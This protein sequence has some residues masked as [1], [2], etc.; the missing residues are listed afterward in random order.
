[1]TRDIALDS[2]QIVR[3]AYKIAEDKD[4]EGAPGAHRPVPRHPGERRRRV[5]AARCE[6]GGVPGQLS[7]RQ[8]GLLIPCR[9]QAEFIMSVSRISA[10]AHSTDHD[11]AVRGY[12]LLLG[13]PPAHEFTIPE[14]DLTVTVFA[15]LSV[16]SGIV[17]ALASV[18]DLRATAFVDSL[19][20]TR[21]QLAESGWTTRGSLG[22][23]NS[24]LARD[25]DG[26]LAEFVEIAGGTA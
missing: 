17:D 4:I 15:G 1:V 19:A 6:G 9:E 12:Q 24:L 14:R 10:V 5:R 23:G 21:A 2:E 7:Q 3:R 13:I 20:D 26:M 18:R 8:P 22:A 25:P 11:A 16:I